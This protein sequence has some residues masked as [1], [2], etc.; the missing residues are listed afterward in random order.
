[1]ENLQNNFYKKITPEDSIENGESLGSFDIQ[2][3]DKNYKLAYSKYDFKYPENIQKESGILGYERKII[4]EDK[5]FGILNE[6][7]LDKKF[8]LSFLKSLECFLFTSKA[9]P[10]I[11]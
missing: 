5:L 1:M 7:L 10:D 8:N 6:I 2:F 3:E 4:S 9:Y 11:W